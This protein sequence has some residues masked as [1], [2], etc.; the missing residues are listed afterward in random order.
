MAFRR[1]T[2]RIVILPDFSSMVRGDW[3]AVEYAPPRWM[4]KNGPVSLSRDA[5]QTFRSLSG[6][7]AFE[8]VDRATTGELIQLFRFQAPRAFLADFLSPSHARWDLI[9][10]TNGPNQTAELAFLR[11]LFTEGGLFDGH[12]MCA[13]S[14][15]SYPV[16]VFLNTLS[17]TEW[18]VFSSEPNPA[19]RL[20][21]DLFFRLTPEA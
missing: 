16:A 21:G 19:I 6:A 12:E 5:W 17:V 8:E 10:C 3:E 14:L 4:V 15:E 13:P 7:P 20:A 11:C 9:L 2:E 18:L 1:I